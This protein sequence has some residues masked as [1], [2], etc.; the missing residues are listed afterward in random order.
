MRR[1]LPLILA[2]LLLA[3]SATAAPRDREHLCGRK[4]I[5]QAQAAERADLRRSQREEEA[6]LRRRQAVLW[7]DGR[8]SEHVPGISREEGERRSEWHRRIAR[9]FDDQL[10]E[11]RHEQREERETLAAAHAEERRAIHE[12]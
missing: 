2:L 12:R 6:E 1:H 5:V 3:V 7:F 4:C 10:R 9:L 8:T 11:L